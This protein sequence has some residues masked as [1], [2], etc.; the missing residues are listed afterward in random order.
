M[1]TFLAGVDWNEFRRKFWHGALVIASAYTTTH[2]QYA[3]LT[4]ALTMLAGASDPPRTINPR[5]L[6]VTAACVLVIL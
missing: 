4:P 5:A 2:P 3:W 1:K 6:G